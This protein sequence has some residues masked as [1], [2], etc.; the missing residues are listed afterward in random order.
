MAS[1][2]VEIYDFLGCNTRDEFNKQFACTVRN[3][4]NKIGIGS[5]IIH[6]KL[7]AEIVQVAH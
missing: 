7:M 1:N 4:Q 6:V 2:S 5:I 3:Y